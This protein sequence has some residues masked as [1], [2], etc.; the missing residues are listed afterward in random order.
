M[1][2]ASI[3][4]QTVFVC[5]C[6]E[7]WFE[8]VDGVFVCKCGRRYNKS[9]D[10]IKNYEIVRGSVALIKSRFT[11]WGSSVVLPADSVIEDCVKD[12]LSLSGYNAPVVKS[13]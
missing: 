12:I 1:S 3:D 10:E 4:G 5:V 6:G 8:L 13:N 9:L 7:R 2:I 11:R